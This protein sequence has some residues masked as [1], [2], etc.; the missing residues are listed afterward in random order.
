MLKKN[1]IISILIILGVVYALGWWVFFTTD[2][3]EIVVKDEKTHTEENKKEKT[4]QAKDIS[5]KD[6]SEDDS[7]DDEKEFENFG[8]FW[9]EI[10]KDGLDIKA[11]IVNGTQEADLAKGVGHHPTTSYPS[12]DGGNVVLSGHRWRFGSNPAYK[13]FK[14]LD[15]LENGDEISLF[16]FGKEYVYK[17]RDQK[18]VK[19]TDVSILKNTDKSQLTLYTCTPIGT[20]FRRLVYIA[21]LEKVL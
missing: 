17:V 18:V 5:Q 12:K 20:A 14:D 21:D 6:E 8:N 4:A 13:V 3:K 11:P 7:K 19:D 2:K 1:K 10:H 16:Y 9:I 15:K